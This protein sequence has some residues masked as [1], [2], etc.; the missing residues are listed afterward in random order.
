MTRLSVTTV[1]RSNAD[2]IESI[3]SLSL[4]EG[5]ASQL[6]ACFVEAWECGE[7]P[8]AEEFLASRG[9]P[10][11]AEATVRLIYEEFCLRREAGEQVA[12]QD[13][14]A[15]FPQHR[16]ELE[17]LFDCERLLSPPSPSD[18]PEAGET[19]GPFRLLS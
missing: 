1:A 7:R 2:H 18:F 3:E 10:T 9:L 16:R 5:P 17:M 15:R 12:S 13:V 19:L 6:V 14:L 4:G 11:D 8:T